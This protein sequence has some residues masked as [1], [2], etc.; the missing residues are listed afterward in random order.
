MN[1]LF[2]PNQSSGYDWGTRAGARVY[3]RQK[4]ARALPSRNQVSELAELEAQMKRYEDEHRKLTDK[5][6]SLYVIQDEETVSDFLRRHRQIQPALVDAEPY[7]RKFFKNSVLSLR[8]T[9]DE[10]GWEMLYAIVQW[11]GDPVAAQHSLDYFDDA[12]WLANSYPAGSNLT[13]TYRL[14]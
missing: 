3:H 14:V 9:S 10:Q 2:E 4:P 13:F 5:I 6:R 1:A 8:A 7:L 11:E 12:W